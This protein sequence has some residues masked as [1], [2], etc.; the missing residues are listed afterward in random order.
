VTSEGGDAAEGYAQLALAVTAGKTVAGGGVLA[1]P[2]FIDKSDWGDGPWQDEPDLLQWCSTV[3]PHYECQIARSV[4]TGVLCGYVAIPAGHPAHGMGWGRGGL[5]VDVHG[6][7]TFAEQGVNGVW[8]IGFVSPALEARMGNRIARDAWLAAM[9]EA[10]PECFRTTYKTIAYVRAVVE[11]LAQQLAEMAAA[12]VAKARGG[13]EP[14]DDE[15]DA[16]VPALSKGE[17]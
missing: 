6:D 13:I 3:P 17:P 4:V 7:L 1:I 15:P 11:S 8:V 2:S 14:D 10:A 12:G 9:E 5:D 16:I